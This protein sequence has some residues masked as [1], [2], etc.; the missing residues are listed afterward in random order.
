MLSN[1]LD[2]YASHFRGWAAIGGVHL[3]ARMADM[4][5][6]LLAE[7]AERARLIER[8]PVPPALRSPLPEGIINLDI[9]RDARRAGAA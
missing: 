5:A 2:V 3:D 6:R 9:E 4:L 7:A 1:D 8:A